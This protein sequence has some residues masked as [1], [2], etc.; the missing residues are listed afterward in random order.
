MCRPLIFLTSLA[1]ALTGLASAGPE[2]VA[3]HYARFA[4]LALTCLHQ[5][6]PNKIA[7]VM[8]GDEDVG[9]PRELTP[10]FYGCFDWH[11][12]V[13]GHWLLVRLVRL[14]PGADYAPAARAALEQSFQA[15]KVAGELA[16][17]AHDQRGTFERPYGVA[18][19]LQLM[20]EL[21]EWDDPD[22]RRWLAT[23]QPLEEAYVGKMEEWLP[24][25]AYAIRIG[26]HAQT[27]FAFGLFL[28]WADA[29]GRA[30]FRELVADRAM[31][32]H[33]DDVDCP[34]AYEPG[35]QDFLSP[36]LAEADLMRRL[37]GPEAFAAWLARFL[38]GLPADGGADW[39]PIGRVTDRADGKLAH[40]DGLNISRAWMLLGI[41]AGLPGEDPRQAALRAAADQHRSA[42]LAAVTGEH[43]EGG[44][45]LGSFATYLVS[46]RWARP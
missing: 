17:I 3:D 40:L 15:T 37:L 18:W 11:S 38:P 23:L 31:V 19:L 33:A 13:H 21:R 39:L 22:A 6:Y 44:H 32:F 10:V 14:E 2:P 24:K 29:A 35:G 20:A 5:E 25:L 46:E 16:Y 34:L 9:P 41:A 30:D 4:G 45:W 28:D 36:C 26:E 7:H 42:G 43:Y 1:L 27:A 12:A 8:A